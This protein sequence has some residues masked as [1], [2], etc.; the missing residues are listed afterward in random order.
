MKHDISTDKE[1]CILNEMGKSVSCFEITERF[2]F[3]R[4]TCYDY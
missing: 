3:E 4:N 1:I 2:V